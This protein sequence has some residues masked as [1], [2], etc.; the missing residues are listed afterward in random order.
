VLNSFKKYLFLT[1]ASCVVFACATTKKRSEAAFIP[2][3]YHN[4]TAEYN[5]YFN[6]N[7]LYTEAIDKLNVQHQDNYTQILDLYPYT[8]AD[9]PKAIAPDMDKGIQK[10]SIVISLHRISDWVDDSYLLYGKSQYLKQDYESAKETFEFLTDNYNPDKKSKKVYTKKD[11][12]ALKKAEDKEKAE[13]K[14]KVDKEKEDKKK[15]KEKASESKKKEKERIKKDKQKA[16]KEAAKAKKKGKK[17]V[18]K[19][20]SATNTTLTPVDEPK[21]VEKEEKVEDEKEKVKPKRY[22]FR[23]RPCYQEARV[24]LARTYIERKEFDK[25]DDIIRDMWAD[26]NTFYDIRRQLAMVRAYAFLEQKQYER[27]VQPLQEAIDIS[28]SKADKARMSFIMAQIL[29]RT[30]HSVEAIAMYKKVIKNRPS[31]DMEFNSRL[32]IAQDAWSSG[33]STAEQAIATLQ[34]MAKDIKNEEYRDQI[35]YSMAQVALKIVHKPEAIDYLTKSL[36]YSSK[37]QAQKA[38]SYYQLASLYYDAEVFAKAKNYFDSTL[39]VLS[40][41]DERYEKVTRFASSLT[42]IAKNI[43]IINLQ[44]S[45]LKVSSLTDAERKTMASKIKKAKDDEAKKVALAKAAENKNNPASKFNGK[46]TISDNSFVPGGA[47]GGAAKASS[48]FAYNEKAVRSGKRDFTRKWGS[49]K[50]EDNWRRSNRKNSGGSDVVDVIKDNATKAENSSDIT[51][52]EI[53]EILKDIPKGDDQIKEAKLKI[54][55]AK[56]TLGKLYRDKIEYFKKSAETHED[57]LARYADE[58]QELET[59]YYLYLNYGDLKNKAKQKVYYDKIVEKYASTTYGRILQDPNFLA[60]NK[61]EEKD[62][63]A[64]YDATYLL[65]QKGDCKDVASRAAEADKKFGAKNV[66][67]AKFALLV[68]M[69]IGKS[70]GKDAYIKALKEVVSKFPLT[71]EEKRAKEMLRLLDPNASFGGGVNN[72]TT[73]TEPSTGDGPFIVEDDKTHYIIVVLE[74]KDADLDAVKSKVAEYNR[75]FHQLE[76][77]KTSNVFLGADAESPLVVIRKFDTKATAMAYYDGVKKNA[78]DYIEKERYEV[79]AVTQ[80]NYREVLKDKNIL[81]Y[82]KFFLKYYVKE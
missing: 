29:Q 31:Y 36:S 3:L 64:F 5:G 73:N 11:R 52:Q 65:F 18:K 1:L 42:D 39:S 68:A 21:K 51:D 48:F 10:L 30:Q 44:D 33:T 60:A 49:R 41:A 24:W 78:K 15:D 9:N 62:L 77:L 37:N 61:Q 72:N 82:K 28:H 38:E 58:K 14:E 25:A 57:L 56:F 47:A 81:N 75:N 32:N 71:A 40:K 54:R 8:A 22:L 79:Y 43:E 12:K 69:C 26:G 67:K 34:G 80:N 76:G 4:I 74:N 70:D 6:A 27:A 20:D 17:V 2:K 7:V 53:N 66:F 23:H 50:L 45:L 35:Y 19:T 13:K 63:N 46:G 59:W 55:D 16:K